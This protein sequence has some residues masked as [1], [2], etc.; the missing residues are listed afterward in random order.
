MDYWDP[1]SNAEAFTSNPDNGDDASNKTL[2][3]RNAWDIPALTEETKSALLERD[4][5]K[6]AA[7]YQ[8][9]QQEALD[10]SPFVMLFQQTEVAGVSGSVKGY[11]LGPTFDSNFLAPISKD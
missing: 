5:D 9:L 2:A 11:K 7:I 4:N 10:Q 1:N 3:W 6:R 8:K